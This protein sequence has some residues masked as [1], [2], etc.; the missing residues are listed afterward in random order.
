MHRSSKSHYFSKHYDLVWRTQSDITLP[1][2][3]SAPEVTHKIGMSSLTATRGC[4]TVSTI[5][6]WFAVN[7]MR[8]AKSEFPLQF[9][10]SYWTGSF[11]RVARCSGIAKTVLWQFSRHWQQQCDVYNGKCLVTS[12]VC[13]RANVCPFSIMQLGVMPHDV[14][15]ADMMT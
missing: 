5:N 4:I 14:V 1:K 11:Y 2:Q 9:G 7:V 6:K 8:S 12:Q 15:G 10:L 13:T 3:N